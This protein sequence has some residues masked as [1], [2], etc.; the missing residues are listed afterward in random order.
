[1]STF[2]VLGDISLLWD[3]TSNLR[4]LEAQKVEGY[5]KL[6]CV[7]LCSRYYYIKCGWTHR[8]LCEMGFVDTR[9]SERCQRYSD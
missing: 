5:L 6:S 7:S 2:G 4:L 1:M 9:R 8:P 3:I